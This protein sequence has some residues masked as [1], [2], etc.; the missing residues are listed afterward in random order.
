MADIAADLGVSRQLVSLVLRNQPGASAET[1][2][3]VAE[4]ARRL[5]YSPHAGARLLRQATS[6]Q[7]G[8]VFAPRHAPGQ[9][10][11]QAIYAHASERG[12]QVVLSAMT[13]TRSG[14][15]A[16]EELLGYRCAA[17]V[18][19]GADLGPDELRA[20]TRRANVPLVAVGAG[21][22]NRF[23]D[24]VRSAGD[25][26]VAECARYLAGLGHRTITYVHGSSMPAG[27]LRLAGYLR[28]VEEHSIDP[29]VLELPGDYTEECGAEA[30][31]QLLGGADLPTAVMMSNDHAALG[32]I[33]TLA[34]AG[35]SVPGDVSV[36]GFDDSRF[37]RFS[38]LD[39]STVRQDPHEMGRSAIAAAL[40][41]IGDPAKRPG[42]AVVGTSLVVRSSTAPPGR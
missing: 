36:T 10:I 13:D 39:L 20:L 17:L 4:A 19:I 6:R 24:V 16:V 37:A 27:P 25:D 2:D 42:E 26:G 14:M 41:R 18:V 15:Q 35:V 28:A 29:V 33:L 30:G 3:R 21:R 1:R 9:E 34:R 12:Y 38:A 5:G 11:V 32:L 23:Y 31:R 40:R 8:V 22:R 7:L